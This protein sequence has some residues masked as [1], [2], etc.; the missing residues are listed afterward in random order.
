MKVLILLHELYKIYGYNLNLLSSF[1]FKGSVGFEKTK[2][3]TKHFQQGLTNFDGKMI[4]N[5]SDGLEGLSKS[6]VVKL[7]FSDHTSIVIRPSGTESKL[8]VYISVSAKTK[9]QAQ[10]DA[11]KIM[12]EL[13]TFIN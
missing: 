12:V 13:R 1:V 3:I 10:L 4:E 7:C 8:K 9:E 6:D 2:S 5:Y 11:A